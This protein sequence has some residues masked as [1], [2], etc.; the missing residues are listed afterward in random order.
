[1]ALP[2]LWDIVSIHSVDMI[3]FSSLEMFIKLIEVLPTKLKIW[4]SLRNIFYFPSYI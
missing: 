3:F 2:I 4:A 1:M